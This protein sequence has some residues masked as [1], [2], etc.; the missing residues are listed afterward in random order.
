MIS[1]TL[2][3]SFKAELLLGVHDFRVGGDVFKLAL[4][5][6]DADLGADTPSYTTEGEVVGPGYTAGG[7]TLTSSGVSIQGRT[8]CVTFSDVSFPGAS[9][10]ARGALVYNSTPSADGLGGPVV[11]PSVAVLNFGEDRIASG[12]TLTIRFPL[13]SPEG[14]L[15]GIA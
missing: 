1:Q 7:V 5:T 14:A 4:Y 15:V 12:G 3:N 8:A 10:A 11:N 2:T 9:F 13:A 6:A